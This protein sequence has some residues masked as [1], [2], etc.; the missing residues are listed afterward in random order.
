MQ[1]SNKP[2]TENII[3]KGDLCSI[4]LCGRFDKVLVNFI[5]F[6]LASYYKFCDSI[7]SATQYELHLGKI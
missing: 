2:I 6:L 1:G 3:L 4:F 7:L 5:R